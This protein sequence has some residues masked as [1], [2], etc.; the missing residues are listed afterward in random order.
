MT[1]KIETPRGCIVITEKGTAQLRWNPE[2]GAAWGKRFDVV[3]KYVDGEVLRLCSPMVPFRSGMLDKSGIL[4]TV[5]GKGE[6][7]YNAPY[8]RYHYYG[9]LMV[10]KAPKKLTEYNMKYHGAP[11]RGPLW[12]ER[13]KNQHLH[14]IL[15]GAAAMARR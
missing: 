3:Q 12:F 6:V 4:G 2:F 10:G 11:V 9:K 8:A 7:S 1:N 15:R 5:T 14:S 13:M